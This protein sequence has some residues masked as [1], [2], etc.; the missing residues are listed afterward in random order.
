MELHCQLHYI[1]QVKA[2]LS[3]PFRSPTIW[4]QLHVFQHA[5][6]GLSV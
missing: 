5:K 4:H 2:V 1:D 3:P 6:R